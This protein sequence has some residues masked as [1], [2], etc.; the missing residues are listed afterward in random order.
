MLLQ[1]TSARVQS[2]LAQEEARLQEHRLVLTEV[3]EVLS[4]MVYDVETCEHECE[5][6]RLKRELSQANSALSEYQQR[7]SELIQERQQAYEYAAKVEQHGKK[8]VGRFN[9]HISVV[10]LELAKKEILEKEL[11]HARQQNDLT[12]QL[13]RELANAQRDIRE[14]HR[15]NSIQSLLKGSNALVATGSGGTRASAAATRM[16]GQ[17]DYAAPFAREA[18]PPPSP[19][20]PSS[21]S[22]RS[23]TTSSSSSPANNNSS[24]QQQQ[25]LIQLVSQPNEYLVRCP[26]KLLMHVF[27]FLDANSV[28]AVSL[29]N[30]S[31]LARVH[32]MFGMTTSVVTATTAT[33]TMGNGSA[34]RGR[35]SVGANAATAQASPKP[36]LQPKNRSQSSIAPSE[37][38]KAQLSKVEMIVKSLKKDEIKLFHEMSTRVKTLEAH[39]GLVQAEKEDIAARLHGAENVRDFLM[40][41]L[42]DLE[43]TLT[44]TMET[45][46]KKDEQ[47]ALDR[48]IIGFLDARTQEYE[49]T[50]K[51]C[52]KQN[53]EYRVELTR[54]HEEHGAKISIIQD[55]VQLLNQEKQDLELQLRSQ[56]KV[57]VREVKVLRAQNQ[58]LETEKEQYFKQLKQLKHALHHLDEL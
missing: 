29:T 13:S 49:I 46:A 19:V 56:R 11:A 14:L 17:T 58:Q 39:L 51:T 28:F 21:T 31:L 26:D 20:S 8:T 52:A 43:D 44:T 47:A 34:R 3:Q 55:M 2:A 45:N 7:E 4:E 6:A 15:K 32:I 27:A 22:S 36:R 24:S 5:V 54:L 16:A 33:A 38:E 42:K 18:M 9:E 48:E 25:L 35:A 41:K 40:E 12:A 23:S 57:L 53:E 10:L 30:H 1:R 37:K 50:L